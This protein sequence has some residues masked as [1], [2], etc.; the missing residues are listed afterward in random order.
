MGEAG[1]LLVPVQ[2]VQEGC[3]MVF[4]YNR[5]DVRGLGIAILVSGLLSIVF[6]VVGLFFGEHHIHSFAAPIWSGIIIVVTGAFCIGTGNKPTSRCLVTTLLFFAVLSLILCT[7]C[8]VL[9]LIGLMRREHCTHSSGLC[10]GVTVAMF[11]ITLLLGIF[12]MI[13][14]FLISI[15]CCLGICYGDAREHEPTA[16]EQEPAERSVFVVATQSPPAPQKPPASRS[17]PSPRNEY[18]DEPPPVEKRPE[19]PAQKGRS[20][21]RAGRDRAGRDRDR[22][23]PD[24]RP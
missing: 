4:V 16:Y 13:L 3:T 11:S 14:C 19:R 21:D 12:Q 1:C 8:W 23:T 24:R 17:R 5:Y 22:R 20:R 6:G 18:V 15:I 9:A 10:D 7:L 2:E